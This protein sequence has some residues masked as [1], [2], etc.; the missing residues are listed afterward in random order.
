MVVYSDN[1]PRRGVGRGGYDPLAL[2]ASQPERPA[3]ELIIVGFHRSG[4]S[5]LT[6][7]LHSA[8]LFVGEELLG[9]M[10]SNPY[11]HFEDREVL[12]IHR[13][14][15]DDNG[16]GWQVDAPP[17][18]YVSPDAWQRMQD[19]I[20]RRHA[21]HPLWGFKEPRVCFFLGVWKYLLPDAKFVVVYRDP[22]ET[23]RSLHARHAGDYLRGNG[24]AESHL[25]FF[26]EPDHA[27]RLWD[28]YNRAIINFARVH[29]DDCLVVAHSGLAAGYPV[30][31]RVKA[32][33]G[34]SLKPVRTESV[35]DPEVLGVQESPRAV[36][37]VSTPQRI[38][39][40]WSELEELAARTDEESAGG[41]ADG[42]TA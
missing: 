9:A 12:E 13:Q 34:V 26:R 38:T 28:T 32:R 42:R 39:R 17:A 2:A 19:L 6:Q 5:L 27:L 3:V 23:T 33:F 37:R 16:V 20:A 10:P 36:H 18:L 40:T 24:P 21:S 14:I 4:T 29:L 25:R 8:G 1:P 7:L 15:L 41:W 22:S 30:V 35:F 11:G 31:E